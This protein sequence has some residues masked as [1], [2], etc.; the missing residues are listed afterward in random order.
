MSENRR[1][2]QSEEVEIGSVFF[3]IGRAINKVFSAIGRFLGGLLDTVIIILLFLKKN[4]KIIFGTAAVISVLCATFIL[5][6]KQSYSSEMIVKPNYSSSK[7]LYDNIDYYHSLIKQKDVELLSKTLGLPL[8]ITAQIKKIEIKPVMKQSDKI[9][10]I[11]SYYE[12]LDTNIKYS[13]EIMQMVNDEI[14]PDNYPYHTITVEAKEGFDFTIL[15][16]VLIKSVAINKFFISKRDFLEASAKAHKKSLEKT[17]SK[18]DTLGNIY[19]QVLLQK[20]KGLASPTS[21][22]GVTRLVLDEN[23]NSDLKDYQWVFYGY[24]ELSNELTDVNIKLGEQKP[25][26][27]IF[28][29]FSKKGIKIS[30]IPLFI[31]VSIIGFF[32]PILVLLFKRLINF[33][34]SVEDKYSI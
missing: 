27:R 28:S 12:L 9:E 23:K 26:I 16:D 3:Y 34:D 14:E 32:L 30:R 31:I 29:K 15:D 1:E 22:N 10:A 17:M 6:S 25:P 8:E 5:N 18:L 19:N 33:L 13:D 4:F 20:S 11:N 21:T 2:V 7:L 24:K